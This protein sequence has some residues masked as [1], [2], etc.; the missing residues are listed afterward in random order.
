LEAGTFLSVSSPRLRPRFE[1]MTIL[2]VCVA[3]KEQAA[4]KVDPDTLEEL[5]ADMREIIHSDHWRRKKRMKA[6]YRKLSR[7]NK[8]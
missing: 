8:S 6:F 7:I 5:K 3:V 4:I 1:K 2:R